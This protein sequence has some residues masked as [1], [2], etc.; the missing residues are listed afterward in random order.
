MKYEYNF[1]VI[2]AGSG[3]LIASNLGAALQAKV[4][5]V[6]KS[7]MGGDCLNYGCVPSKAFIS[8][9]RSI[10]EARKLKEIGVEAELK[11]DYKEIHRHIHSTIARIAPNDSA[12]RY[13][14]LGVD[15]FED[16]AEITGRHE[17]RL[18]SSG[19]ILTSRDIVIAA[20]AKPL[21]P[22]IKGLQSV[23]CYNSENI[24]ELEE[25]P[26]RFLFLGAGP[27]SSELAQCFRSLGSEVS[28]L[29]QGSFLSTYD[30][31]ARAVVK[32]AFVREGIEIMESATANEFVMNSDSSFTL[33]YEH[34]KQNKERQFD[35]VMVA[36]GRL[37]EEPCWDE[38]KLPIQLNPNR[39]IQTDA[40][41]RSSVKNI[42]AVGD[43]AGPYQFT[44][45]AGYQGQI[46]AINSVFS[47]IKSFKADYRLIPMTI[48]TEPELALVG[49]SEKRAQVEGIPYQVF[50]HHYKDIDRAIAERKTEGFLKL[51]LKPSSDQILGAVVVG[52]NAQLLASEI[53]LAMMKKIGLNTLLNKIYSYPSLGDIIK[54]CA[55]K[56]KKAQSKESSLRI[57]AMINQ[58]R[59][60]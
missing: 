16:E 45:L 53:H 54:L 31:D 52:H 32:E 37:V 28:I 59:R 38:K 57:L 6:E 44:H 7:K 10:R 27:I 18:K 58:R 15:V 30:D 43:I 23:P 20:G 55:G 9:T 26:K 33:Y 19:V 46:A 1:V 3:G 8:L 36:I 2:G 47:F 60:T 41:L 13:R 49:Y 50:V 12:E 48:F 14:S 5:L 17:V 25:L 34:E 42:Y 39:T 29:T 4:A 11:V 40:Y 51:L 35:A 56:W 24:W 22:N 21:I